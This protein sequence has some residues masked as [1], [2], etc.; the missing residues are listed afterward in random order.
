M[1]GNDPRSWRNGSD[2]GW[3]TVVTERVP[4]AWE[5]FGCVSRRGA[6]RGSNRVCGTGVSHARPLT[7]SELPGAMSVTGN[8]PCSWRNGSD[9]GWSTVV[10][11]AGAHGLG[12]FGCVSR[13]G[14]HPGRNRL[15]R[16]GVSHGP[17]LLTAM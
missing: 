11:D 3:S 9:R 6:H 1:T 17:R 2:R 4:M 16:T 8:D 14:A 10:T 7:A 5:R 12:A 15:C 13:R